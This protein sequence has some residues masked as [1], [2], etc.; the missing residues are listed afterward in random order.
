MCVVIKYEGCNIFVMFCMYKKKVT[1][2]IY[3][4]KILN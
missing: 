2:G 3:K 4:Y 1:S